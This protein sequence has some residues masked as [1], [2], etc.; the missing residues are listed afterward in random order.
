MGDESSAA[1]SRKSIQLSH[2]EKDMPRSKLVELDPKRLR[3]QLHNHEDIGPFMMSY[4]TITIFS[5]HTDLSQRST[6]FA[7]SVLIHSF[8]LGLLFFGLMYAP[9][10]VNG[11]QSERYTIR[12]LVLQTPS[13][14]MQQSS[15]KDMNPDSQRSTDAAPAAA[16]AMAAYLQAMRKIENAEP[17]PHTLLQPEVHSRLTLLHE[18]AY[19]LLHHMDAKQRAS[20]RHRCALCD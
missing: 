4:S 8:A 2:A 5:D 14:R 19:P 13:S 9:R 11:P 17:G 7:V 16:G 20:Q 3:S 15:T 12:Q 18:T 1:R 10:I 6:S